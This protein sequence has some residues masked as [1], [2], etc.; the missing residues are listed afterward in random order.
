MKKKRFNKHG[1]VVPI[2][3]G[4]AGGVGTV[5]TAV[6]AV[7]ATPKALELIEAEKNSRVG[8]T[9][10][11]DT[12]DNTI[13]L[14]PIEIVKVAW[15][16]YLPAVMMGIATISC[17]AG[18]QALSYR[19]QASL[20]SAY[21][22]LDQSYRNYRRKLI[23]L[24]GRGIHEEV[25]D[26]LAI[27]DAQKT[28]IRSSYLFAECKQFL[29]EDLS[30]PVLFYEEFGRR[31]FTATIEQVLQAEY[32]LNR[33]YVLRG[34]AAL[35]EFYEFLGLGPVEQGDVLGWVVYDEGTYWIDFNHRRTTLKDGVECYMIE[36]MYEPR[37]DWDDIL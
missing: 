37:M 22:F 19:H 24:H 26:A 10:D 5:A 20:A 14:K 8:V 17:I 4:I 13:D 29:D 35:N 15:K 7:R 34:D 3:L 31:H 2:V 25:V 23:E 27:E 6:L 30:E 33:N 36:M 12:D 1:Q 18:S 9:F 28:Y 11:M 21:A 16:P 32:H